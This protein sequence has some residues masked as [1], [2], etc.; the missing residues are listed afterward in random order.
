[1][2]TAKHGGV[3][4]GGLPNYMKLQQDQTLFLE[5]IIRLIHNGLVAGGIIWW[6]MVS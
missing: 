6:N 5:P 2:F 3:W 1:M 4:G